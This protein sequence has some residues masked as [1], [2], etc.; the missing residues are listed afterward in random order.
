[1]KRFWKWQWRNLFLILL[2]AYAVFLAVQFKP[3]NFAW[4]RKP[5]PIP[6]GD[7]GTVTRITKD[8]SYT[9]TEEGRPVLSVSAEEV[10]AFKNTEYNLRNVGIVFYLKGG[11]MTLFCRE[12]RFDIEEKDAYVQ[13]RVFVQMP[14]GFSL[15]TEEVTYRHRTRELQG[16]VSLHFTF[17]DFYWGDVAAVRMNLRDETFMLEQVEARGPDA[18]IQAPVLTG[19]LRSRAFTFPRG[20]R[21]HW[22]DND[23]SL[24]TLS[25]HVRT[26]VV[27]LLGSCLDGRLVLPEATATMT[28]DRLSGQMARQPALQ[29]RTLQFEEG[30]TFESAPLDRLVRAGRATIRFTDGRPAE[31]DLKDDVFFKEKEEE[32]H[33]AKA[34]FALDAA[35]ELTSA[36]FGDGTWGCVRGWYYSSD[37]LQVMPREKAAYLRG[38]VHTRSKA[39]VLDGAWIS[40]KEDGNRVEAGGGVYGQEESR[41]FKVRAQSMDMNRVERRTT[42]RTDV[43]SWSKEITLR[44]RLL[45]F[46]DDR[47]EASGEVE[48]LYDRKQ[49]TLRLTCWTLAYDSARRILDALGSVNVQTPREHLSGYHLL[50]YEAAGKFAR[51]VLT[52][53]VYLE[54]KNGGKTGTGDAL[55]A[56]LEKNF[57]V[58]EGCPAVLED[59]KEGRVEA[60]TILG[61]RDPMQIFLSDEAGGARIQR[62][63]GPGKTINLTLPD[64]GKKK[65]K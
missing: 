10:V 64:K 40:V 62:L 41:G 47:W 54:L 27:D 58:L 7:Q 49:E 44:A 17:M 50:G 12:G 11:R 23:F 38:D 3:R 59:K 29:M 63:Q 4:T 45:S 20:V 52:D 30:M 13:G 33:A 19:S 36:F 55:E 46:Y 26:D 61:L 14:N 43:L 39:L 34:A 35:Q 18:W 22:Q 31:F 53:N 1:M 15:W 8:F 16:T 37:T 25:L 24:E 57:F 42:F 2:A 48:A 9:E 21:L 6:V 65:T 51:L 60:S 28:G 56:D 5:L 32:A